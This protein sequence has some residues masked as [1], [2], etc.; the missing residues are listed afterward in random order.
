MKKHKRFLRFLVILCLA[1]SLTGCGGNKEPEVLMSR[2]LDGA[3]VYAVD[4]GGQLSVCIDSERGPLVQL[5]LPEDVLRLRALYANDLTK[6]W[7]IGI[8][9]DPYT[10]EKG[11]SYNYFELKNGQ[12]VYQPWGVYT[13]EWYGDE[14]TPFDF[15]ELVS[16]DQ[17]PDGRIEEHADQYFMTP[18][19]FCRDYFNQRWNSIERESFE[20]VK[21]CLG[22]DGIL[23][24]VHYP[25][26]NNQ[27][28]GSKLLLVHQDD[29]KEP[30]D[31]EVIWEMEHCMATDLLYS[32][33][34][35]LVFDEQNIYPVNEPPE[36]LDTESL[37]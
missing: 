7:V 33:G 27:M 2:Y 23:L 3:H 15:L 4:E 12:Y 21:M 17:L 35:I 6:I 8:S 30:F 22:E 29:L 5:P 37:G 28:I 11:T 18:S 9:I 25:D 36:A 31:Y 32:G 1:L 10:N 24:L 19:F 20:Y 26:E 16:S 13:G 34:H 14:D